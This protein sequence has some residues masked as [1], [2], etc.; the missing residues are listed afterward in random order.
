MPCSSTT[1]EPDSP[2]RSTWS[3]ERTLG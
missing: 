1:G 2:W 3:M